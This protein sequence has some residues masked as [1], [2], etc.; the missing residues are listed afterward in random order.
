VNLPRELNQINN[1]EVDMC[2]GCFEASLER[3][4]NRQTAQQLESEISTPLRFVWNP[5]TNMNLK[6]YSILMLQ[7]K[8][9]GS[10]L[11]AP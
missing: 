1:N 5:K 10:S 11:G 4:L 9:T 3:K 2:N 7:T 6:R 8:L